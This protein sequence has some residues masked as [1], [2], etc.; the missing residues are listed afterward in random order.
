MGTLSAVQV[1][2]RPATTADV[3]AMIAIKHDAGVA[4]WPHIMPPEVLETLPFPDRWAAA[5]DAPDPG[6]GVLVAEAA[7]RIV[8]FAVTRPS[9]DPGA[10]TATGEL[11]GFYVDPATW[12]VGAGRSLLAAAIQAL[13]GAGFSRAT[14][15][16]AEEN[17]RPRRIYE[18]AGWHPDGTDRRRV[19]GGVE[20]VELRYAVTFDSAAQVSGDLPASLELD[21]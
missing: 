21:G 16:T 18:T 3:D 9:G 5:I 17:H 8:G 19:F 20:F 13:R 12:G 4:A 7:G 10:G 1:R 15:W 6:V 14:L 2:I 11:D